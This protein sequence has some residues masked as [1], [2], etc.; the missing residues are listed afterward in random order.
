MV[1]VRFKVRSGMLLTRA[2]EE[3]PDGKGQ[4]QGKVRYANHQD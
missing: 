1:K 2:E 4:G 3:K